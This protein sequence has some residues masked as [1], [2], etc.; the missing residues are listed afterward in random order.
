MNFKIKKSYTIVHGPID[1][2]Y[3]F[4]SFFHIFIKDFQKQADIISS[5]MF[6]GSLR[7]T[8]SRDRGSLYQS[9]LHLHFIINNRC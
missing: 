6:S 5:E 4:K 9:N 3:Y 2:P 8:S 1:D 7:Q